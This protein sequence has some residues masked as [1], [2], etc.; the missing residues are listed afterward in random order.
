V[1]P[2]VGPAHPAGSLRSLPQPRLT[3]GGLVLRPWQESDASA[4]RTAFDCPEIQRWHVRRMDSRDEALA[5]IAGWQPRWDDETDASWAVA[6]AV[7]DRL[8]GQVGLRAVSL[9]DSAAQLS[10]WVVPDARGNGIAARA[11]LAVTRWT[12][13]VVGLHRVL[14]QHSTDN[15]ASC[16][17]AGKLGFR[18]E[19][20]LRS[21]WLHADGWHDVHTH[22]RLRT[23]R[24]RLA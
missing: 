18:V 8:L 7:D 4:V 16:R 20:T 21:A 24:E 3:L 22:A 19:G 23:D 17:V 5:W 12:F 9:S 14:L 2:L 6:N 13:D 1:P 11:A 10:Y 15:Q